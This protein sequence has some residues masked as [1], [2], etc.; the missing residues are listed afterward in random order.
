MS[1]NGHFLGAKLRLGLLQA[2]LK[3]GL[4]ALQRSFAQTRRA[5]LIVQPGESGLQFRNLVLA[6]QNRSRGLSVA[7]SVKIT[8]GINSVPAEQFAGE[9]DVMECAFGI[10]PCGRCCLQVPHD[11][12]HSQQP[13]QKWTDRTV[14]MNDG[15]RSERLAIQFTGRSCEGILPISRASRI[16]GGGISRRVVE[17][18]SLGFVLFGAMAEKCQR[19]NA[20][21]AFFIISEIDQYLMGCFRLLG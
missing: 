6:A 7:V 4:L 8:T 16:G 1:G 21:A 5:Y 19:G 18:L 9:R 14:A 12:R 3:L 20:G 10:P 17:V 11:A 15:N 13:L 2:G